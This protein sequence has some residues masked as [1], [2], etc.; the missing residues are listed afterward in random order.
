[1]N[2]PYDSE[3]FTRPTFLIFIIPNCRFSSSIENCWFLFLR[4]SY[5]VHRVYLLPIFGKFI[6][7]CG[8]SAIFNEEKNMNSPNL[9][10]VN[11]VEFSK[12]AAFTNMF[13][14]ILRLYSSLILQGMLSRS[15]SRL[16]S[17]ASRRGFAAAAAAE[18]KANPDEL[19]LTFA[20]PDRVGLIFLSF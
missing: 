19:R 12:R 13:F 18:T 10:S 15:V 16:V 6:E 2:Y 20:S 1:M 17:V 9:L 11:S 8:Q 14:P 5:L 4:I 3:E 7:F